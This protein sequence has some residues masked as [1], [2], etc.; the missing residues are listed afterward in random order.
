LILQ[1]VAWLNNRS[2]HLIKQ[3]LPG[4]RSILDS[5]HPGTYLALVI[6]TAVGSFAGFAGEAISIINIKKKE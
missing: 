5:L 4:F 1:Q 3:P 2:C 6:M